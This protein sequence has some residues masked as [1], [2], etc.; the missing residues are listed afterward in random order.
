[1][2]VADRNDPQAL[3]IQK[4]REERVRRIR[5]QQEEERKKKLEELRQHVSFL[6]YTITSAAPLHNR[7]HASFMLIA[8]RRKFSWGLK[9][10]RVGL[11]TLKIALTI[12]R[13]QKSQQNPQRKPPVYAHNCRITVIAAR[14]GDLWLFGLFSTRLLTKFWL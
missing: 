7:Q 2:F 1:M 11:R 6:L 5:E 13:S 8:V 3:A 9:G 12:K 14:F 4:E 10:W